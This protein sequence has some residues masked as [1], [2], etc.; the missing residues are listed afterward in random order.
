MKRTFTTAILSSFLSLLFALGLQ[1]SAKAECHALFGYTQT[2]G[3]LLVTFHDSSTST[4]TITTWHWDFG[5]GHSSN[6]HNISHTYAAPGTYQVCLTIHDNHDCNSTVCHSVVVSPVQNTC[7]AFFTYEQI[8][9][10]L[11]IH[12]IDGSS[13]NHD[14]TSWLWTFGDGQTSD[15]HAP[16]HVYGAPGT[17]EVC[18]TIHDNTGC[19]STYCHNVIVTPVTPANCEAYFGYFQTSGTLAI[20]F[21]DSSTSNHTITTWHWDFGDGHSSNDHTVTHT[22]STPGTYQVCLTIHDNGDCNDTYCHA[23]IVQPV[24]SGDC[25]AFFEYEQE[26]NSQTVH[27]FDGSESDHDIIS[28]LWTFGDGTSS[29]NHAPTHTYANPGTYEV[30]LTIHDNTGCTNTYCHNVVVVAII[31][32]NCEA[33][34]GWYQ[35][36]GTQTIHFID[37]S[38]SAHDITSYS[39]NFGDG[40]E[41]EGPNPNHYYPVGTYEVCLTIHD[42][43]GCTDTYCTTITVLPEMPGECHASFEY[44][45]TEGTQTI[46]FTNLSTSNH[47]INSYQWSFGDGHNGDGANPH[48]AY[49][50]PGTYEV[51][52]IIHDVTGCTD[53][54]CLPVIVEPVIPG[55]CEAFFGWYQGAGTQTI[56]FIDSSFSAH[57]I[58]SYSWNFGDGHEG[59]GHNPTHYYP[60]GTYEVCLTIHDNTGCTDTYCT[61]I[62]VLPEMPGSCHAL[63][64]SQHEEGTLIVHFTDV[65]TSP[66]PIISWLWHFGDGGIS[67]DPNPTHIYEN[68]GT[69]EVCLTIHDDHGCESTYCHHIVIGSNSSECNAAFSTSVDTAGLTVTFTNT[70]T[71]TTPNTTYLW[72]FGDGT[73]STDENPVHTYSHHD[74]YTV[75][76]IIMDNENNCSDDVCHI[77]HVFQIGGIH[78]SGE[79][80]DVQNIAHMKHENH[81]N[82][83]N[84]ISIFPNP[85]SAV[86]YIQY[87]LTADADVSIELCDLYGSRIRQVASEKETAGTQKHSVDTGNLNPGVYVFKVRINQEFIIRKITVTR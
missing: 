32:G 37:S 9:N 75:C 28:W 52:L 33:F 49:E 31:P 57:D 3:T 41:G 55:E 46:Q 8:A 71:N 40:H 39:W 60:V 11:S 68:P 78:E 76:L 72:T 5:D 17:Y 18:L 67:D 2:P 36:A 62:T 85:A 73:S 79:S 70:S 42:N 15:N 29:D 26:A 58:I 12:F 45:Q 74:N 81:G 61:T 51:C 48:H 16:T 53:T 83:E 43:T 30:C 20:H 64:T 38:Y 69:Y 6:D 34:F 84:I 80:L 10:S 23:V 13:S 63:F 19:T 35:I 86:T 21:I 66:H 65:S 77:V 4:F 1:T 44:N 22:Y 82:S 47:D 87:E 54:F 59:D 24:A 14:I 27:F 7:E 56:H 50:N 25:V